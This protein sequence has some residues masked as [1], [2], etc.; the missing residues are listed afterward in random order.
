M[1]NKTFILLGFDHQLNEQRDNYPFFR[2]LE[3]RGYNIYRHHE[4]AFGYDPRF[5]SL[6]NNRVT[7]VI[8]VMSDEDRAMYKDIPAIHVANGFEVKEGDFVLLGQDFT[9]YNFDKI[10]NGVYEQEEDYESDCEDDD[11]NYDDDYEPVVFYA[12]DSYYNDGL[13]ML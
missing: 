4:D 7:V 3:Q 10:V 1:T 2:L 12:N 5:M 13:Q 11:D 9:V 6:H 8:G